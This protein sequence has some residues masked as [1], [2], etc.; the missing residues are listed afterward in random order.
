[1]EKYRIKAQNLSETLVE[2]DKVITELRLEQVKEQMRGV[3]LEDEL[4]QLNEK[5][6]QD[7]VEDLK[8]RLQK[9]IAQYKQL[10]R[11]F[12]V[13]EQELKISQ[14]RVQ[15]LGNIRETLRSAVHIV[16]PNPSTKLPRKVYSCL[17]CY[18][19]NL[20]CDNN[21]QC[22]NCNEGNI[23]CLRWRCSLKHKLGECPNTPCK[24]AHDAQG[25]LCLQER[26][27]EW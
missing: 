25:W 16:R 15:K 27:P 12:K 20:E 26:R 14:E 22:R 4:M 18:A 24:P 21:A 13:T 9:K 23:D 6:K 1:M 11:Q 17:E 8:E 7:N 19:N 3:D 10:Q 5:V 2:K